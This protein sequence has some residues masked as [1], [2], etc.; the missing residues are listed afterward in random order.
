MS[1]G[2]PGDGAEPKA[3]ENHEFSTST[4]RTIRGQEVPGIPAGTKAIGLYEFGGVIY[5]AT[6][7]GAFRLTG[8]GGKDE[9]FVPI[10][11]AVA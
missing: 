9:R 10:P 5:A 11:F 1:D 4:K 6:E 3:V 2:T 7:L 8:I